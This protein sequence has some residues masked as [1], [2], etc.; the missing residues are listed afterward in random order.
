MFQ[1]RRPL[2]LAVTTGQFSPCETQYGL[3]SLY[4]HRSRNGQ[5]RDYGYQHRRNRLSLRAKSHT[6]GTGEYHPRPYAVQSSA[7]ARKR[8]IHRE[9]V[10]LP[11]LPTRLVGTLEWP[12]DALPPGA[13]LIRWPS[14]KIYVHDQ[15]PGRSRVLY[16]PTS[17]DQSTLQSI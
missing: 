10:E 6:W 11:S 16:G 9:L 14:R 5:L 1:P 8:R 4:R 3:G 13:P 7:G 2:S 12:V 15:Q 17:Y